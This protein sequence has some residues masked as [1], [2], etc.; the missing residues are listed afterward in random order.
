VKKWVGENRS[1][2]VAFAHGVENGEREPSQFPWTKELKENKNEKR[3]REPSAKRAGVSG[4]QTKKLE[5]RRWFSVGL[6]V[7]GTQKKQVPI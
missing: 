5:P 4:S 7:R 2:G 3:P 6:I 1:L